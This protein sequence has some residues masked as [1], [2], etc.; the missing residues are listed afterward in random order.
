MAVLPETLKPAGTVS[1]N[2]LSDLLGLSGGVEAAGLLPRSV[3][4]SGG[5]NC[6]S[7]GEQR[8]NC[9]VRIGDAAGDRNDRCG[10]GHGAAWPGLAFGD[11]G[12]FSYECGCA[13]S[14]DCG[15][16]GAGGD[17]ARRSREIGL[18]GSRDGSGEYVRVRAHEALAGLERCVAGNLSEV[19]GV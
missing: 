2:R 14:G 10:S 1:G 15:N 12:G 19:A 6:D 3:S 9:I 16:G 17:C 7:K 11:R 5:V 13:G 8:E 4:R 18:G